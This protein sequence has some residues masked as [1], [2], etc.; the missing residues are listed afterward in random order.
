MLLM[1]R[2]NFRIV[3][4]NRGAR[5]HYLSGSNVFR[6]VSYKDDGAQLRQPVCNWRGPQVRSRDLVS[7]RQQHL[8]Y[9]THA[10]SANAYEMYPLNL[11]KHCLCRFAPNRCTASS[12]LLSV[13]AC[14]SGLGALVGLALLYT[15]T[16]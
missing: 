13:G 10:D 9:A 6:L 4:M 3:G 8:G 7:E 15:F 1:G 16:S 5:H 2:A 14:C 11:G 12:I